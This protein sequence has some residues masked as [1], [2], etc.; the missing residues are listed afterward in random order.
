M[1]TYKIYDLQ[2]GRYFGDGATFTSRNECRDQLRSY[3]SAD[4]ENAENMSLNDLLD[5]GSWEIHKVRSY[6]VL[7]PDGIDIE[8][9]TYPSLYEAKKALAKWIQ[10][11]S[12]QGYYSQACNNGYV[13]RIPMHELPDYCTIV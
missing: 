13:R 4:V 10:R 9:R 12:K 8:P 5:V 11:Y 3:H 7:S 1:N 2:L 6:R